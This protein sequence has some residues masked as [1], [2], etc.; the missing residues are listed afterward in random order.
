MSA[1]NADNL[2]ARCLTAVVSWTGYVA[3]MAI[4]VLNVLALI[5]VVVLVL[6]YAFGIDVL[7]GLDWLPTEWFRKIFI[8]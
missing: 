3:G 5:A 1:D 4:I 8:H 2:V 6:K 7:N